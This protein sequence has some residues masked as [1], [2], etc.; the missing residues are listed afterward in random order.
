M[1]IPAED[2]S[3]AAFAP[4]GTTI[5]LPER[6]EDASG[7]AWRWWAETVL[8]PTDGRSFGVGYLDLRP[9]EPSF[10]W[11]ER[12]LRTTETIVPLGGECVVYVGPAERRDPGWPPPLDRFRAFRV[13]AGAGVVLK[14]GVWHGA[15]LAVDAP[16]RAAVLILQGTGADDV[17]V[18]RFEDRPVGIDL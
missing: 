1:R 10:D 9:G 4:F 6:A 16:M 11:A 17:E 18:V 3:A 14:P 5:E 2:L 8:L 15:P 7:P 12:H 13:R